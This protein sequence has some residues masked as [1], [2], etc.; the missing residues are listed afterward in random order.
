MVSTPRDTIVEE[1]F[2]QTISDPYRWLEDEKNPEVKHWMSAQDRRTRGFLQTSPMRARLAERLKELYYVTRRSIPIRRK[3][4]W[5]YVA[6]P[7]DREKPVH[8]YREAHE[9]QWRVLLD[10]NTLSDDG[11][12]SVGAAVPSP[13]GRWLAYLEKVQNRDESTIRV[14]RVDTQEY[15]PL[16]VIEGVRYT[17]VS[18][19]PDKDGFFYTWLPNDPKIP[20]HELMGFAEIRYHALGTS[21]DKDQVFRERTGDPRRFLGAHVSEDGRYLFLSESFGWSRENVYVMHLDGDRKWRPLAEGMTALYHVAAYQ[22]R[23]YIATNETEEGWEVFSVDPKRTRRSAWRRIVGPRPKAFLDGMGIVGGQLSLR[24]LKNAASELLL[25]TLSGALERT[26]ELPGIGSASNLIGNEDQDEAHFSFSSF[27]HPPTIYRTSVKEGGLEE[28]FR[29]RSSVRPEE[30]EVSQVWFPSA[31]GTSVSMFLVHKKGIELDGSHPTLLTGYGGFNIPV[32]PSF[33]K[34]VYPWLEQGGLFAVVQLRGGGEYG[35]AWHQAGMG[36]KKQNVFDDF[37]AAAEWLIRSRYTEP[38][39]L[40]IRGGSNGGL[41]VGAAM[42][43][44]PDLF[45]AVVSAVPLLDMVRYHQVGIGSAWIPEYGD[46]RDP[47]HLPHLLAYSPYH[48]VQQGVHYPPL[49]LLSADSDDRVDPMHARKFAAMIQWASPDNEV[50]LR[51]ESDA[52]HGGADM[53]K[54]AVE[55]AADEL[56]FLFS[57]VGPAARSH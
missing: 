19:T 48:R 34:D 25:Y 17:E 15:A 53:K 42:T 23:F 33:R 21:P 41:L 52:G 39:Y 37:I 27:T 43:Q 44:R 16:D 14:M 50:F 8:Y 54:K 7:A 20:S 22:D 47:L 10:V 40:A 32:T 55:E 35:R 56:T 30:Y 29:M 4:R 9:D 51:I 11:T 24:Y 31:D 26:I 3:N 1:L 28:V 38:Q 18:W 36:N 46:P 13:D 2:G 12:L 5:F 45:G 57:H 6:Y 49:L